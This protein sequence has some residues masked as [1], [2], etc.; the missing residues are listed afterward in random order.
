MEEVCPFCGKICKRLGTHFYV[1]KNL[2]DKTKDEIH[3]I[4]LK[5]LSNNEN[6]IEDICNDYKNLYSLPDLYKK[7]GKAAASN[8]V[9]WIL[10]YKDIPARDI[11]ESCQKIAKYKTIKTCQEKYGVNNPSQVQ[12]VKDKKAKTFIDHYG[13][14]N[15]WKTKEYAEFTSNRW[16]SYT[17]EIKNE[18]IHKWTHRD[19]SISK[20]ETKIADVLVDL[21]IP[22]ETQFKFPKYFHKYDI[23]IKNS[24]IIIEVQG[25]F[26]HANPKLYKETDTFNFPNNL[27]YTAEQI[28]KKDKQN[29]DYAESQNYKI[30][31]LWE[32]DINEN[33]KKNNLEIFLLDIL[34]KYINITI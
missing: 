20:L 16:A 6:I 3:I 13:V 32:Y 1:C 15:V 14:D 2:Q 23:H 4:N 31:Q 29:I 24:N 25:D 21:N 10:K 22:I 11:K 33:I 9:L 7:Y 30:I 27:T 34:N 12:E 19:G 18:L 28:W 26:W 8:H 5:Y 17:A